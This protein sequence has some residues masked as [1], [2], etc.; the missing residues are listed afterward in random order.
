MTDSATSVSESESTR[1]DPQHILE[2]LEQYKDDHPEASEYQLET[3]AEAEE[4]LVAM[5]STFKLVMDDPKFRD[6]ESRAEIQKYAKQYHHAIQGKR[7]LDFFRE[8]EGD[9]E[10]SLYGM[11]ITASRIVVQ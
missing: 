3:E 1:P 6:R 10:L 7:C 2:R 4:L 5:V 9:D 8:L 11:R